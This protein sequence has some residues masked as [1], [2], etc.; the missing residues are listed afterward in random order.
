MHQHFNDLAADL[1]G[2]AD[3]RPPLVLLHGLTYDRRQWD[4][5]LGELARIDPGRHVLAVD[6]PGHGDSAPRASYRLDEVTDALHTA[7]TGAGLTAPIVVGHSLGGVLATVYARRH[8]VRGVVNVDQPLLVGRFGDVLR[9]AEP[10]LRGPGWRQVWDTM[11]AGMGID[12]L[13]PDA[14]DLVRTATTPRQDLLLGYWAE[15]LTTG[16]DDLT[17]QR[18]QDLDAI[19]RAGVPYH[20]VAGAPLDP[21]YQAWLEETL[22]GVTVTVLAGSGHFP[23][24]ARP[25]DFARL[26][27]A[28]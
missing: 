26:L 15:I 5:M 27:L 23:H 3:D 21:A 10:A 1:R 7:V 20:H 18:T 22:P 19:R 12:R 17:R 13:P 2:T 28:G 8:P 24:L 9:Q 16:A 4:P 25:A 6:L 14:R 11:L